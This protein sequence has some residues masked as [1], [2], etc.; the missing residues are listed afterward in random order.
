MLGYLP[1]LGAFVVVKEILANEEEPFALNKCMKPFGFITFLTI[2]LTRQGVT[3]EPNMLQFLLI[4]AFDIFFFYNLL[5]FI[6]I[7]IRFASP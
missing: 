2:N 3:E 7:I 6:R 4:L 5:L 1:T